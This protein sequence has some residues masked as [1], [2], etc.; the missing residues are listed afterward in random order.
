MG[1]TILQSDGGRSPHE[2]VV[3]Y[4]TAGGPPK[5][6]SYHDATKPQEV[7][8]R[9]VEPDC[10]QR[11]QRRQRHSP[12]WTPA[13]DCIECRS[14]GVCGIGCASLFAVDVGTVG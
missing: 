13:N 4:R 10:R 6:G 8:R 11:K 9:W 5:K 14:N 7:P 12:A 3:P 2:G 1:G